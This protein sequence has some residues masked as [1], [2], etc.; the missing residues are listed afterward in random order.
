VVIR[1][2]DLPITVI[3]S[4]LNAELML[5]HSYQYGFSGFAAMLTT[6]EAVAIG[7]KSGVVSV[8]VD[9][10]LELHTTR[11][12]DFLQLLN[13]GGTN[14]WTGRIQDVSGSSLYTQGTSDTIIGLLDTGY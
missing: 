6:T 10:I 7:K 14:S 1:V 9:P 13:S 12:W 3:C 11:S 5:V 2:D 4:G 8:F